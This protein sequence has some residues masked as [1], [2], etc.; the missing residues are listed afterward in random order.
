MFLDNPVFT[1]L[2]TQIVVQIIAENTVC[3][4]DLWHVS[5]FLNHWYF[6]I[7]GNAKTP[8]NFVLFSVKICFNL[9]ISGRNCDALELSVIVRPIC[10]N[11]WTSERDYDARRWSTV[12]RIFSHNFWIR[13]E[14][15]MPANYVLFSDLSVTV[16]ELRKSITTPVD[17]LLLSE[18]SV[19]I[20]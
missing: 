7:S 17:E 1:Q 5:L 3:C 2:T 13:R 20:C 18:K 6:T 8:V 15:T 4:G 9:W 16:R 12:V 11:S 14:I 19:T 10:H